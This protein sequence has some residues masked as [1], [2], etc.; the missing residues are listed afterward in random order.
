MVHPVPAFDYRARLVQ[1]AE[2]A[3]IPTLPGAWSIT[4]PLGRPAGGTYTEVAFADEAL[5]ELVHATPQQVE[6]VCEE[7]T[8]R[9]AVDLYGT[10][11]AF[12]YRPD[13]YADAIERHHVRRREL[14]IVTALTLYADFRKEPQPPPSTYGIRPHRYPRTQAEADMLRRIA[15]RDL[16]RIPPDLTDPREEPRP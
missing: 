11:W 12:T 1:P 3:D 2:L 15:E 6:A 5:D 9:V 4:H 13:Q 14:V 7:V 16:P 8:R 10:A